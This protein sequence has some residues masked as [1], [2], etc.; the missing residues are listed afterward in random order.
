MKLT[1]EN[2]RTIFF[3]GI[4]GIGMSALARYFKMQG[5]IIYGYDK[6]PTSLTDELIREGMLIHFEDNPALIPEEIDLVIYT[7]AIPEDLQEFILLRNSL[8]PMIK[9]S[10]A[11]GM[12]T[13]ER[14]AIAVAGSHGKT[15]ISSMIAH[16]L[17]QAGM[18]VTALIGGISK[19]YGSNFISSGSE[20]IM[21]VEADEYDR[22]FLQLYPDVAVISAMDPDHLDIYGSPEELLHS[23]A[24][25]A[26]NIKPFGKLVI[27][28]G[29]IIK[30]KPEIQQIVYAVEED[31]DFTG[32]NLRTRNGSLVFDMVISGQRYPDILLKIP[33]KHNV[34]NTIAAAAVCHQTG[35]AAD[36]IIEGIQTF[37]GVRR[38][39]DVRVQTPEVIYIDDYAHHPKELEAFITAVRNQYPHRKVTGIFQ[40]HLYSRTFDFAAEFAAS[41]EPLDEIWLLD[42]YPAREK[43]IEGVSS[44]LIFDQISNPHKKLI[45]K[46]EILPLLSGPKPEVFLTMGAG[47]IDQLVPSVEKALMP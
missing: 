38:R 3:L 46:D 12:I 6:T 25:F 16:I 30:P 20:E 32:T 4:G 21:V 41:L 5:K 9:R 37:T 15:S 39:F 11:V 28:Q 2:I 36:K 33:G 1:L 34:E 19:N 45:D 23:Y 47:D 29:L 17:M 26:S 40:P 8:I 44:Q 24:D 14:F 13:R 7:P 18:P 10:A 43:P 27:R 31:A 35:V 42:I 22:S